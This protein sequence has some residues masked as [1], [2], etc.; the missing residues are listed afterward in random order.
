MLDIYEEALNDLNQAIKL[1]PEN[2]DY[3]V[4]RATLYLDMKK[5]RLAR[6]DAQTAITLGADPR[7]MASMLKKE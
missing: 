2:P 3:Y 4:S 1:S 6:Q 7:E 5:R